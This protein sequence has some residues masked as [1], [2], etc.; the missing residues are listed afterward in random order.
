MEQHIKAD[1]PRSEFAAMEKYLRGLGMDCGSGTNRLSATVMSTD[2]YPHEGVDLIWNCV[3]EGGRIP[4]PFRDKIFDFVFASHVI[5]DFS[6]DQIQWM[7]DE[8][9]RMIKP[10]GYFVVL[11]PCMDG[12]RYPKWDEKFTEESP[13]VIRGERKVGETIG[14]PS[15]LID[16]DLNLCHK[17]RNASRYRTEIAQEDTL[18]KNRMTIDFVVKKIN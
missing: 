13:E 7:F 14:N 6:P 1:D 8:L 4:Y 10:G 11:G 15:H 12:I 16:W 9:L 18:P 3:H 5:E 17:L 2:W